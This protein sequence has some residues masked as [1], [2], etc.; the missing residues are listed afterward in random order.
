MSSI[1]IVGSGPTAIYTLAALRAAER[2]LA[3]T[4][5][6][7]LPEAGRGTPYTP[8]LNSA[9]MLSNIASIEIPPV[10]ETLVGWLERQSDAE[11]ERLGVTRD[12]I[13]ERAFYPRL[14]LG[15]YL[16]AQFEALLAEL[17]AAGHSVAVRTG[18]RVVD[19]ELLADRIGVDVEAAGRP[20]ARSSFDHV[21]LATGHSWPD[22][23]EP[24][25]GYFTSP[26]PASALERIGNCPVGI[27]GTSLSA[28]DAAV[29]VAANHGAFLHD[30]AGA[31]RY[32]P[33]PGKDAFLLTLM[34]RKGL[35]PEADFYHPLPYEP[36][37]V[38]TE[39]AVAAL[40]ASGRGDLLDAVFTLFAQELA[41]CDPDYAARIDLPRLTV[42]SFAPAY[43]AERE[44][45]DPFAWAAL[46]LAEA[47]ANEE[48]RC[49]VPWRYAILRMHE[50]VALAA[51]H[52]GAKDLDRFHQHFKHV[53]VDDYAT[54]P[55]QSIERLLALHEAGKLQVLRLGQDYELD[56]EGPEPGAVL[57]L[58]GELT[59]FP[60]FV[61]A[62]GQ[63][64]MKAEDLPF[65][66][67]LRQG[68]AR[69]APGGR[70]IALD[71]AFRLKFPQALCSEIYCLAL[72]FLLH[73]HPFSQ[74]ITSSHELGTKVGGAMLAATAAKDGRVVAARP[75]TAAGETAPAQSVKGGLL[76]A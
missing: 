61:E 72:P 32:H 27:R 17:M 57:T 35:L 36:L 64:S 13:D 44:G 1:A 6:E 47:K 8:R 5:F 74:G 50:V 60:A 40:V 59:H 34:S 38:C 48:K 29:T 51:P 53:F 9:A 23:V 45:R 71:D 75:Q 31:L 43:F 33:A 15:S 67:L 63:E 73:R 56:T 70:G 65:P 41:A 12:G 55:H 39:E 46:N 4:V 18:H 66:T 16:K 19:A 11:L 62:M 3:I 24:K 54:V 52:F 21:V 2:P 76:P 49:T 28:I 30:E 25:P 26:W 22:R 14:V 42:E 7:A 69:R 58:D 68:V 20:L 10:T 37:A